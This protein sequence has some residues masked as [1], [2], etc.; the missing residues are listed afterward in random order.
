MMEDKADK[1]SN[2]EKASHHEDTEKELCI[3]LRNT[4]ADVTT[5]EEYQRFNY[6]PK[7]MENKGFWD[8]DFERFKQIVEKEERPPLKVA[9]A[10]MY[11]RSL[12]S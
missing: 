4:P 2:K 8:A 7:W 5:D 12:I 6:T 9:S 3:R 1:K 11:V 10:Y